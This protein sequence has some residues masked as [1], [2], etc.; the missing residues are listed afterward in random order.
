MNLLTDN[1]K[2][3]SSHEHD[4]SS[5]WQWFGHFVLRSTGFPFEW[6]AE[7]R[8]EQTSL[9]LNQDSNQERAEIVFE[10]EFAEKRTKLKYFF[11]T[12]DFRQ[13]IFISNPDMYQHIDRYMQHFSASQR[14]SKVKRIEKKL[15]SYLQRFCAK[16]ESASFFGPLNYGKV[17]R[18]EPCYWNGEWDHRSYL[19]DRESFISYWA[20]KELIK[21]VA[22]E[23]E[24]S[25]YVPL[26]ISARTILEKNEIQ[27]SSENR[28]KLPAQLM[29]ILRYIQQYSP[30]LAE[31]M[32][33]HS[34]LA[35]A[36]IKKWIDQ[37]TSKGILRKEWV[38]PSTLVHPISMFLKQL[39]ALPDNEVK[40][41]WCSELQELCGIAEQLAEQPITSKIEWVQKLEEKFEQL[42][43]KP[44]RRGK[45]SLYADRFVYY[46]DAHGHIK[47]FTLGAPFIKDLES[48]MSGVLNLSAAY[49]EEVWNH[50]QQLGKNVFERMET[51]DREGVPFSKFIEQLREH[52]PDIPT[53]PSFSLT[54]HLREMVEEKGSEL[55]Q[56]EL[57]SKSMQ[58]KRSN[59]SLYALPDLFLQARNTEDLQTGNVQIILAKLH[60]HLLMNNWMTYFYREKESLETELVQLLEQMDQT[61][62]TTLAGIEVMRRN[63]AFYDYP[64]KVIEIAE[65]P[66]QGKPSIHL[67]EL[68]V[69]TNDEGHLILMRKG[70]L[71]QIE[72]Y[73]PLADQ[74][75]YLPF[76]IFSK[77]MLLHVPI[78]TGKHTPRIVIDGVV[79]Q[80]ERWSFEAEPL[81]L[82]FKGLH[83]LELMKKSE[84]WRIKEGLP[85]IIYMK[86]SN[87]RKPYFIDF[88]NYFSLELMQQILMDNDNVMIEEMLPGPNHL[89]L[90][91]NKGSHSCELRMGVYK[92]GTKEEEEHV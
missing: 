1:S 45:A 49:G 50:Y 29:S 54:Q 86:G 22:A 36:Q 72:L 43:G 66:A 71:E 59:R 47:H 39:R 5:G 87:V 31:V 34:H 63:K 28:I 91:S 33:V 4:F 15:F 32:E 83:G 81:D 24:L 20:V 46:E 17:D 6:L 35:P 9:L 48:K 21:A 80:R 61:D 12:E 68:V 65:K 92:I 79:Y 55:Q 73:I 23:K 56:V 41:K 30:C 57:S 11:D 90:T 16:N 85:E 82:T 76:A 89:W 77:P 7:L 19:Q 14:P 53:L 52:Y 60:H 3:T 64:S 37:L 58:I 62:G 51:V 18:E 8:M 69:T 26:H 13:A 67:A 75:F 27:I 25:A 10:K 40:E 78:S 42:T 74:V 2:N 70:S 88:K 38:I 84:E 44:S